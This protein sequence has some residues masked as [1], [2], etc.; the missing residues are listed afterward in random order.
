MPRLSPKELYDNYRKGFSGCIWEQHVYDHLMETSKYP[1]F[2]DA[3][4]KLV[5]AVRV[6]FQHHIRVC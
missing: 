6:N 3:S 1:L 2:G 5:A 4:K